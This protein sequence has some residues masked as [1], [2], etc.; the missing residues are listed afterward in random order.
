MNIRFFP[1]AFLGCLLLGAQILQAQNHAVKDLTI[2]PAVGIGGF[3]NYGNYT[4]F[5]L[6]VIVQAEYGLTD[7]LS[8]GP[9]VSYSRF[10]YGGVI[11]YPYNW[12]V[13]NVGGRVSYRFMPL[14]EQ[15]ASK[16]LNTGKWDFY[17]TA[18]LSY[19]NVVYRA[20]EG[21]LPNGGTRLRTRFRFGPSLG[22]KYYI[23]PNIAPFV[24][25]GITTFG[26]ISAG[27]SLGL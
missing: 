9:F 2:S 15:L 16:E 23:K 17:A 3:G 11:S 25:T 4:T 14:V 26:T 18:F 8:L 22:A 19:E 7:E 24:E 10:K 5:S 27:V 13:I 6:P 1:L 21:P 12:H 20:K